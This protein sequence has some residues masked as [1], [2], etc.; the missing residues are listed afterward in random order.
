[1]QDAA[2][3]TEIALKEAADLAAKRASAPAP[4]PPLTPHKLVMSD[5]PCFI[6]EELDYHDLGNILSPSAIGDRDG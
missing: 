2:R 1:M 5:V 6:D 3:A 4:A